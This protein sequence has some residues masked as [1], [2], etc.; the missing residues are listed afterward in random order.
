MT[1]VGGRATDQATD[2]ATEL[3]LGP[4]IEA[5]GS[6]SPVGSLSGVGPRSPGGPVRRSVRD[7][8][9]WL[10]PEPPVG[11]ARRP[12]AVR[13]VLALA[14]VVAGAGV[15]LGRLRG[16]GPFN[17]VFAEDA[18]VF[19]TDALNRDPLVAIFRPFN[20]YY[21][22]GP[23]LLAGLASLAPVGWAPAVMSVEAAL[24]LGFIGLGAYV[25]SAAHLRS[26]PARL[27]V[28]VPV[29]AVAAAENAAATTTNNLATLQ[30]SAL[31]AVFWM[32]LW[33]PASRV[34]R[35]TAVAT[36]ALTALSTLLTLPLLPIALVRLYVRRRLS[37]ALLVVGL[38]AGAALHLTGLALGW[39]A[40]PGYLKP[41]SDLYWAI[42]GYARW[43]LP[44]SM[45]G[46]RWFGLPVMGL[47]HRQFVLAEFA[48]FVVVLAL[49]GALL[50]RRGL[51]AAGR[52]GAPSRDGGPDGPAWGLA[53]LAAVYAAGLHGFQ[54]LSS[55]RPEERY[56]ITPSLLLLVVMAALLRP[57]ARLRDPHAVPFHLYA[58]LLA[59]VTAVNY[60]GVDS[61]RTLGPAWDTEL[62]LGAVACTRDPT[63]RA[64]ELPAGGG[65]TVIVPCA[66]LR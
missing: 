22:V 38:V 46:F 48:W 21:H 27:M 42:D 59:V 28:S 40:R 65:G 26:V 51:P 5:I 17:S 11:A 16:P 58:T 30:F 23:R 7:R 66:M 6:R 29:V 41:S 35:V 34:G 37:D 57:P 49:V 56:I 44:H 39:T 43:G 9:A 24:V 31:Y 64:V 54:Y 8:L 20:G 19:L 2:Q 55:G 3:A 53:G 45:L 36:V 47:S 4:A 1:T 32:L 10:F 15:S 60:T 14:A 52:A 25:A 62:K 63:L 50:R 18:S 33:V 61:G 13:V 12:S